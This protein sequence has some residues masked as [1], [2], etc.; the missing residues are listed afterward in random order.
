[1]EI[2]PNI[3]IGDTPANAVIPVKMGRIEFEKRIAQFSQNCRNDS[4]FMHLLAELYNVEDAIKDDLSKYATDE[5]REL[6]RELADWEQ[7][8]RNEKHDPS[9]DL[10]KNA[11][12]LL[13]AA[14]KESEGK[15]SSSLLDDKENNKRKGEATFEE[16]ERSRQKI[17]G[18]E[19]MEE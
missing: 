1:M 14:P 19:A 5:A 4:A 8:L 9:L 10:Q 7:R 12:P 17:E 16:S 3:E 15:E 6:R 13:P 11:T 18:S 2:Q